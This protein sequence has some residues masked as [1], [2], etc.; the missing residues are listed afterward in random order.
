MWEYSQPDVG[1][2]TS[3]YQVNFDRYSKIPKLLRPPS[4]AAPG[5]AWN[6]EGHFEVDKRHLP[7]EEF[8]RNED[9]PVPLYYAF[10]TKRCDE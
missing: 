1:E 4:L 3:M 8:P 5:S 9:Y 10:K 7:G 6:E 2:S